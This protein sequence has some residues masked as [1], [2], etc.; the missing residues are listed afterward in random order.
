MVQRFE[1]T[2]PRSAGRDPQPEIPARQRAIF[3][4]IIDGVP[5]ASV[6][7]EDLHVGELVFLTSDA[8]LVFRKDN[9]NIYRY[10]DAATRAI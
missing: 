4:R 6:S 7:K 5:W 8:S 3:P 10:D 1:E 9:T 2:D